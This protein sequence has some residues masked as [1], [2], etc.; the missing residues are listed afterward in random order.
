MAERPLIPYQWVR[1]AGQGR[2]GSRLPTSTPSAWG[3]PADAGWG[4]AP[5]AQVETRGDATRAAGDGSEDDGSSYY[6]S[7]EC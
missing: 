1:S 7:D 3:D 2:D 4:L 5:D 6:S